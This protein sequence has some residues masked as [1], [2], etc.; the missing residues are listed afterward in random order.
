MRCKSITTNLLTVVGLLVEPSTAIKK[1]NCSI[2][3]SFS[4]R[5]PS[6]KVTYIINVIYPSLSSFV[7]SSSMLISNSIIY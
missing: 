2:G 5:Q 7:F 3:V 6:I 4:I 1:P